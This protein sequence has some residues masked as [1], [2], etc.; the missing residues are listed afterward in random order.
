VQRSPEAWAQTYRSLEHGIAKNCCNNN[1]KM[2]AF[3]QSIQNFANLFAQMQ[4]KRHDSDYDPNCPA[5]FKSAVL[6]DI[7]LCEAAVNA[8][9]RVPA[10]HRRAFAAFVVLKDRKS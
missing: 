6:T 7:G 8:F 9:Y 10:L 2:S 3:P 5:L 4:V 1:T